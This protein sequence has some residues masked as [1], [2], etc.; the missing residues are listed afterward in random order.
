VTGTRGP[1]RRPAAAAF[2]AALLVY[3][4][5][6]G[7]SLATS[8]AVATYEV[9]ESIVLHGSVALR[10]DAVGMEGARG[11]DGRMYAPFGIGQSLYN[12]PFFLA[13]LAVR[14]GLG[15]RIGKPSTIPKA[16]VAV[17]S[18]VA[19]AVGVGV[20]ALFA[21]RIAG[22][23]AQAAL[24]AALGLAFATSVWPYAKF[25]FNAPL[26]LALVTAGLHAAW[27]AS[28]DRL[29][30]AWWW[31]GAAL[32]FALLV[33]HEMILL[34]VPVALWAALEARGNPGRTVAS[35]LRVAVPLALALAATLLYNAARFG[36]PLDTGYLRD[37]TAQFNQPVLEG[38]YGLLL[39]PGA[40][41]F[42][43][44]PLAIPGAIGLAM[45]W[46]ADRN[47]A[48]M[49]TAAFV[50]F[51]I[52]YASLGHWAG[53]RSYGPRYLVPLLSCLCLPLAPWFARASRGTRRALL[54]CAVAG[55]IVQLPGV[56]V[57]FSKASIDH[58]R[59]FDPGML[60]DRRY[61]WRS[62]P[63]LVNLT[64]TV[65]AVPRN[66]RYLAG[67]EAA[68]P[69]QPSAG[70]ASREFA[71]QF[72]FSLDF[73]WLYLWHLDAI[74]AALALALGALP[75]AAAGWI[76]IGAWRAGARR[77]LPPP[78]TLPVSRT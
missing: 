75:I 44:A 20:T 43:Y 77:P 36:N 11:L 1:S 10:S 32:A 5:T 65:E 9:T 15:I 78:L 8:D 17:G 48:A 58:A 26:T 19:A 46:R 76:V 70:D 71:Q 74:P 3:A 33:R 29:I 16:A 23:D 54:A 53:G 68:P 13:G 38:L 4:S 22:G 63:L 42:L 67:S 50:T 34:I 14:D 73:W 24:F 41:L 57:D 37:S 6:T 7:G 66:V 62:A 2:A 21:L 51:L 40:S 31:S 60:P 12:I 25:G 69:L 45:L 35:L 18:A 55:A 49:L 52:F 61:D 30:R 39:S 59:R 56:L 64:A 28:R 27:I 72:S 47:L